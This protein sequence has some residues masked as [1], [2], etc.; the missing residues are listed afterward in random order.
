MSKWI[1]QS[2][3]ISNCGQIAVSVI[4]GISIKRISAII[5]K[6]E[7]TKTKDLVK[8]LRELGY[9]CP[10]RLKV[11]KKNIP[12]LAIG[13]LSYPNTTYNW[14]WVAIINDKIYDGRYGNKNGKV[15]W[16]KDWKI[17]SYLPCEKILLLENHA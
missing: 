16:K 4:T 13:K 7:E 1:K 11:F 5:G 6:D 10:N 9:R 15:K 17:T 14:H 12:Q 3:S 8:S 2:Y